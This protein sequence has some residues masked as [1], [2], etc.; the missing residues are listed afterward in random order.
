VAS[1]DLR[2]PLSAVHIGATLL[3]R[4]GLSAAHARI[5]ERIQSCARRMDRIVRDLLDCT[6]VRAG[7][8][9]PLAIRSADLREVCTRVVDELSITHGEGAVVL[10]LCGDLGGE[11]DPDRL[12]QAVENLV[13]N[14]LKYAP[15]GTAVRVRAVGEVEAVRLE[16][17]ND[18]PP[19][20]PELMRTIFDPF[21]QGGREPERA[22]GLG[23]GLFIVRSIVE[24]HGGRVAAESGPSRPVTFTVELPRFPSPSLDQT[25]PRAFRL[26]GTKDR[27]RDARPRA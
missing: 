5:A 18:G 26:T 16:V 11:W 12:E 8:G 6:R 9:I 14:A 19:I 23:L 17:E 10:A 2:T 3:S 27:A 20:A 25:P 21:E 13:S 15:P 7:G 1:H 22:E 24:A 4:S